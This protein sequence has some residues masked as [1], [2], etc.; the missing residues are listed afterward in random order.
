M[1]NRVYME[2]RQGDTAE[3]V[4]TLLP[5]YDGF[6]TGYMGDCVCVIVLW[7]F[8]QAN[9]EYANA[10]GMHGSGGVGA[11]QWDKILQDVP[12]N[13][14]TRVIAIGGTIGKNGNRDNERFHTKISESLGNAKTEVF[15]S[16]HALVR[17]NG[18]IKLNRAPP[19]KTSRSHCCVIL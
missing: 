9:S 10:R 3:H 13:E 15:T 19:P 14:N 18:E 6:Y 8:N 4:K 7:N 17:I 2:L 12:N 16:S 11:I 5:N 1:K